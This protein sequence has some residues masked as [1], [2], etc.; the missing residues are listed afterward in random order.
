MMI[1]KD[2]IKTIFS[3]RMKNVGKAQ[4][5]MV[6]LPAALGYSRFVTQLAK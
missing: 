4:E 1:D 5:N 3:H 2:R 6:S